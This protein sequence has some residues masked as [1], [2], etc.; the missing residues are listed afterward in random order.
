MWAALASGEG[1]RSRSILPQAIA[2]FIDNDQ[3]DGSVLFHRVSTGRGGVQYCGSLPSYVLVAVWNS[4]W[5]VW[6]WQW[7]WCNGQDTEVDVLP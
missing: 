5:H 6:E 3:A 7:Q 2:D 4:R 1:R